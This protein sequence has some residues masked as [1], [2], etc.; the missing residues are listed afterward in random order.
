M[1]KQEILQ[2]C[3]IENLVVKLPNIK[4][5]RSLYQDVAKALNLIGGVWKGN[6]IQ[7]FVFKEDPTELLAQIANGENRN[8][9]KEFQFFGTPLGLADRVVELAEIEKQH[10]ILEPSAGQG[11][12]INA[13]HRNFLNK[14]VDYCELMPI[15][16]SFIQKIP[17]ITFL[18]DDFLTLN[19]ENYYDRIV[20]NPPFK[21]NLDILHIK[22]M[23]G[24]LKKSGRLVT[25]SSKHWQ[26]SSNKKETEFRN[27]LDEVG[28]E[29]HEI[30]AG[31]FK[32]SGTMIQSLIIVINK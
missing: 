23:Y 19:K 1:T 13:V 29:I 17:N 20:A 18:C 5:D 8:L 21:N 12:I 9:K 11:A 22:H 26:F 2:Q 6:K 25:I 30:P 14:N 3:T 16:L 4:L 27:W 31:T 15:N 32:E 24:C 7:G 28:A 10:T